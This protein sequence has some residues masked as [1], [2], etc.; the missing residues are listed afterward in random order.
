MDRQTKKVYYIARNDE[1]TPENITVYAPVTD[2]L[3]VVKGKKG[4]KVRNIRFENLVMGNTRGDYKSI[5]TKAQTDD[6]Q[7]YIDE[8]NPDGFASDIQ[9]VCWAHG[10]IEFYYAHG[11]YLEKCVLKNIGVHA[12]T[13][14]EGCDRIQIADNDMFDLGAGAIKITGGLAGCDKEDETHGNVV[15]NNIITDSGN[16][17]FAACGILIMHSYE[18]TV[19][20]NE[21]SYQYYSGISVGWVWGYID[22]ITRDNLIEKNQIHHIGQGK[23]SDMGGIYLL[24][25]QP[26]TIVRNNVIHDVISAHYGGW[27]LYT[28]E[29]SSYIT[30][31][32]NICYNIS[33]NGFHQH[34][35]DRNTVRNNIFVKSD[36]APARISRVEL[37]V[38]ALF[39]RNIMVSSGTSAY[40]T[41]A[42]PIMGGCV[43]MMGSNRNVLFDKNGEAYVLD[44]GGRKYTLKE[45]QD[46]FAIE[47]NTVV[48][49]PCFSD[50]ENNDFTLKENS[51]A[52]K[53]GF[54]QIDI[55]DVGAKR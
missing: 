17:Y 39:E 3:F 6:G 49:D 33:C 52:L 27:G 35:G 7:C 23:L 9:S 11:C 48:A 13:V 47:E 24:G 55:K 42:K 8:N 22:S 45:A 16:R 19:A 2:K 10:S 29:G 51:P 32:N 54:K 4:N 46:I 41:G 5:Y 28:D 15:K 1:Q 31:E 21:I 37:H 44:I 14:N 12:I 34:F 50:Y 25:K 20:N 26:G 18:N 53:M 40:Q 36:E 43:H 30:L 38:G